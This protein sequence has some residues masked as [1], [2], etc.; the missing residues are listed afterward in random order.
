MH[1]LE[2]RNRGQWSLPNPETV[3]IIALRVNIIMILTI[4]NM[5][6]QTVPSGVALLLLEGLSPRQIGF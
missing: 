6:L 5:V 4:Y 2:F 1:G 3:F